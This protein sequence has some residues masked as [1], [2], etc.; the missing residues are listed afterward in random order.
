MSGSKGLKQRFLR[1]GTQAG[2]TLAAAYACGP[3]SANKSSLQ[4]IVRLTIGNVLAR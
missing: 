2:T 4:T 3:G 1:A